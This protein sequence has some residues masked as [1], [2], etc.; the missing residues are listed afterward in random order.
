MTWKGERKAIAG[1]VA[2]LLA[3]SFEPPVREE[4]P[5]PPTPDSNPDEPDSQGG[6]TTGT[7]FL[8][9]TNG[10]IVTSYHV[11]TNCASILAHR[12]G[13]PALRAELI[14]KRPTNDLAL[15]KTNPMIGSSFARIRIGKPPIQR[16][17]EIVVFGFPLP[18]SLSR[19]GNVVSGNV[20]ALEGVGNDRQFFQISAP[21]QPG[22]SGGPLMDRSGNVIGVIQSKLN[23]LLMAPSLGAI[24]ENISFALKASIL[25]EF[26]DWV[27]TTYQTGLPD[28]NLSVTQIGQQAEAFTAMI[29]C[30]RGV[31]EAPD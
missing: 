31:E 3:N 21:I 19:E 7:G 16:G 25:S 15:L 22:N 26:L 18:D 2:V 8:I 4:E 14:T 1:R 5:L 10:H 12:R 11:V 9:S 13:T 20:A 29:E 28:K 23:A 6:T 24:P 27:G 17:D 30:I